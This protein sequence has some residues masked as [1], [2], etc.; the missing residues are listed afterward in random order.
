[1]AKKISELTAATS[2]TGTELIPVVQGG[3]SLSATIAQVV[4][5]KAGTCIVDVFTASGTWTKRAGLQSVTVYVLGGGGGGGSGR[6]GASGSVRAGGVGGGA[7]GF[8][9]ANFP[10]AMLGSSLSVTVGAAGAGGVAQSTASTN[11]NNGTAGGNTSFGSICTAGGGGGGQGG[12]SSQANT[13]G[14]GGMFP[15]GLALAGATNVAGGIM[16]VGGGSGAQM[17]G[18]N[19]LTAG[20]STYKPAFRATQ[21][22]S[23]YPTYTVTLDSV[24]APSSNGG[25]GTTYGDYFPDGSGA[26]GSSNPSGNAW[27][28]GNAGTYGGGGGGGGAAT[29]G[30]TSGGGGNGG[31]GLV[32]VYNYF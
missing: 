20:Y 31:Q 11:G 28:G 24:G 23:Q 16:S 30:F 29:D 8:T 3:T 27:G 12:N 21:V 26:G 22:N 2:L 9:I 6:C 5:G 25:N 18:S 32:V 1:M 14:G 10:A 15:G 19:A 7:G 17:G 13:N 4:A